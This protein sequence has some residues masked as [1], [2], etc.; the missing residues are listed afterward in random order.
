MRDLV[1]VE[2]QVLDELTYRIEML[3]NKVNSL[4]ANS[5]V[6]PQKWIDNDQACARLTTAY[7]SLS[8]SAVKGN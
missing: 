8:H 1:I 5:G 6:A 7:V 4:Y 2:K 3:K